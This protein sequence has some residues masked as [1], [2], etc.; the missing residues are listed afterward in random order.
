MKSLPSVLRDQL[1]WMQRVILIPVYLFVFVLVVFFLVRVIPGDPVVN[2]TGGQNISQDQYLRIQEAMGLN[3]SLWDQLTTY[4]GRLAAGDLGT[5]FSMGTP[6]KDDLLRVIPGTVEN[7][8]IAAI[9]VLL[10]GFLVG[11]IV[12]LR[13]GNAVS[14]GA[15]FVARTAGAVPDFVIGIFGILLFFVVMRIAPAPIGLYDVVLAPP[16]TVTGFALVDAA[17][18][19]RWDVEASIWAHLWLPT[20]TLVLAYGPMLLKVLIPSLQ[21]AAEANPTKFAVSTG[22]R[23]G[24]VLRS[25]WRRAMPAALAMFGTIFGYLLGGAVIIEQLF[26]LQG[27]AQYAVNAV[28]RSDYVALQG[29]LLAIA[30]ISLTVFLLVDI[31]TGVLDPRR[32]SAGAAA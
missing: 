6:V 20:L 4:L 13:P 29:I 9:A 2:A 18:A 25:V 31:L 8:V 15:I 5:S 14:R 23:S 30:L 16:P 3:G 12:L 27:S 10:V 17:L 11:M 32:R 22:Q 19:R 1:W 21:A 28:N 7:A 26:A 24:A